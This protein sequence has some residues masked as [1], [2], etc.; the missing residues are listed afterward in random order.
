MA[1]IQGFVAEEAFVE[2]FEA[3]NRDWLR[4]GIKL[5]LIRSIALP[6]LVL[7]GGISMFVLIGVGGTMALSGAITVGELAAFTALLTV[8][9]PPLRSMGWMMSVIQRGRAALERIFE[10]MDAPI[11]RPEGERGKVAEAGRGPRIEIDSLTFAYPDEPRR[12]VLDEIS[13]TLEPG[14]VVGL[15]GRTGSGKSTLL[16]L[17]ARL[18]NPPPGSIRIDGI[19]LTTFDLESWRRRLAAVPQRPFL[20]SD[21]IEA[22]IALE[23]DADEERVRRAIRLAALEGDIEVLPM[24][25]RTVVGERGI[26]LS[27]G[28]RQRVA[29]ARGLYRT[30]DVLILDDV[31]SAVDHHTE[32]MLV[33]TVADLARHPDGPTVLISSHRLSALRQCDTILVLEGGRLVDSG[34]HAEL[35]RRPG[36]YRDVW[37]VQS[38]AAAAE[39]EVAS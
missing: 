39:D 12:P 9:L 16:R 25:L 22:N 10:L 29:L 14:S 36:L 34:P 30:S 4:I 31:L 28:Q 2:R 6:L 32:S 7:S 27:G 19:D 15:F 38:Q 24:G 5:A 33:E 17:L 11:E 20:F 37:R 1:A 8:F 3:R 23:G 18:Y 35:V 21:T 26:M 13:V